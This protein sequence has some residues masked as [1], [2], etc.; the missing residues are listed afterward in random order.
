MPTARIVAFAAALLA[1]ASAAADLYAYVNENG[2][3]IISKKRPKAPVEYSILTDDGEFVR[4]VPAPQDNVPITH[5]R[6]WF[7]PREPDPL[8]AP[9]PNWEERIPQIDI[10]EVEEESANHEDTETADEVP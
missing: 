3:Y 10:E 2:D 9:T 4:L 5:W 8:D 1:S 6:P 7:L